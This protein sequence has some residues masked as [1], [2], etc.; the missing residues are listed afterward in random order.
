M[1]ER[2]FVFQVVQDQIVFY[3]VMN[4]TFKDRERE[5]VKQFTIFSETYPL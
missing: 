4:H 1:N 5:K 2:M 3:L